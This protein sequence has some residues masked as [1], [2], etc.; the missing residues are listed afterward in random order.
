MIHVLTDNDSGRLHYVLSFIFEDVYTMPFKIIRFGDHLPSEAGICLI[1]GEETPEWASHSPKLFVP[2]TNLLFEHGLQS[3]NPEVSMDRDYALPVFFK[4]ETS[5]TYDL[6]FDIFAMIFYCLSRYEE[7]NSTPKDRFGRFPAA[8]SL[9]GKNGFLDKP[10]IDLWLDIF[11]RKL[12][13]K[14][15]QTIPKKQKFAV[16]PTID[17]DRV[18]AYA[19][20]EKSH[21]PG[22]LKDMLTGHFSRVTDRIRVLKN[23]ASDP[24]FTFDYLQKH[25]SK[26]KEKPLFFILFAK[27]PDAA[28]INHVRDLEVFRTWLASFSKSNEIGLHPSFQS[29]QSPA[30]LEDEKKALEEAIHKPVTASR[31]HY[32][33]FRLPETYRR[34]AEIGI[35]DD[36]SMGY[37]EIIGFRA[38]T[39]Y[40]YR[41]YDMEKETTTTLRVHPFQFMDVTL[42]KYMGLNPGEAITLL[43]SALEFAK[44][45]GYPVRFIWHNSSFYPGNGWKGWDKVFI[46]FAEQATR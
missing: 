18:W 15:G 32:I 22:L 9:A 37:P 30:V 28:D 6:P 36:Y 27:N 16:F 21:L 8:A 39:G 7:Y 24:F 31:Q 3:I 29:H 10:L 43:S 45:T 1:Y 26:S 46:C 44:K 13:E 41:W 40:T 25:L 23:A 35:Q 4:S 19:H 33:L 34:L 14:S 2:K 12:E 5:G 38:S 20:K 11:I 17:I 42:R